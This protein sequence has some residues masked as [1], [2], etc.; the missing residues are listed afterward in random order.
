MLKLAP[1]DKEPTSRHGDDNDASGRRVYGNMEADS[2]NKTSR[3]ANDGSS[4]ARSGKTFKRFERDEEPMLG[5]RPSKDVKKYRRG[6]KA[7]MR[8]VHDRKLHR[9]TKQR[10]KKFK[11]ATESAAAAE[12]L[13]TEEAG[14]LEADGPLERTYK[15]T[16]SQISK[17]VDIAVAKKSVELTLD[18]Y[19]PY[20]LNYS[21]NGRHML[22]GGEKGHIS[23]VDWNNF[24]VTAEFHVKETVRDV[25]FL[26][27]HMLFATAQKK[28]A[29]IYD[30]TGAEVHV[31]R[32]HVEPTALDFL[33]YHFLLASVGNTGYLKYQD[34]STGELVVE[35]RTK[36]GSCKV[37]RQNPWNAVM[38]LGHNNGT[39]TMW[40]PNMNTPVAK[41]LSHK[42]P[43]TALAVDAGGR[44]MVTAGMDSRLKVW[45]I[46]R[47]REVH[48]YFTAV[49]AHSVDISQRGMV[50]VGFGSHIQIWGRDFALEQG[51]TK[52]LDGLMIPSMAKD[53]DPSNLRL[54]FDEPIEGMMHMHQLAAQDAGVTKAVS[55]Y[56]RHELPGKLVSCVRFR[57]YDDVMAIGHTGGIS[58]IIIP[59]AGEPNYD[60]LAANPFQT[61]K[62]RQEAEVHSLLDKIPPSMITLDPS[63]VAKVDRASSIIQEKE[64]RELEANLSREEKAKRAKNAGIR[65]AKKKQAN[66]ITEQR[67]LYLEKLKEEKE[68]AE[69]AARNAGKPAVQQKK[70]ALSRF[71]S[72]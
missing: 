71:Y 39:V 46:R 16:Q 36:L 62:E 12:L 11:E 48:S 64:R 14:Y 7:D 53:R 49:P 8:D 63:D 54:P 51:N 66:V 29:Y 60:S 38:C 41:M 3:N 34:V 20:K 52:V 65:K 6:E 42:G 47:F 13:L 33:P 70:T 4:R 30:H 58:S 31:L 56:M 43:V 21:R 17:A 1:V 68:A 67:M 5:V 50:G 37:M 57:P 32:H 69:E 2:R 72:K 19:G 25:T 24:S 15:F 44:Y 18:E 27:N 28:Y 40:T 45:D 59:G 9:E 22:I 55:P 26:H 23:V 10:E 61:K 35:H